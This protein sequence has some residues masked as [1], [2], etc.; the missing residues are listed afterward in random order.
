MECKTDFEKDSAKI[1]KL[2]KLEINLN[3]FYSISFLCNKWTLQGKIDHVDPGI[4]EIFKFEE[5]ELKH[6]AEIFL[7]DLNIRIN[8]FKK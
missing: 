8:I 3:E 1:L 7:F 4:F 6:Q 2:Q 5:M